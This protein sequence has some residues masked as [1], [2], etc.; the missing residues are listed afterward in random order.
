MNPTPQYWLITGISSGL[1]QA[2]ASAAMA[3][4]HYVIGTFRNPD[5]AAAFSQAH[6]GSGTAFPLDITDR[7]GAFALIREV[8]SRFGRLDVLVNNAG[9]GFAGAI[10]EASEAEVRALMEVSF[11]GPLHLTQAAL[12]LMRQQGSGHII[13]ISSHGGIKAFP[14]FGVYHAGKFAL[15][16]FS[17][18]LAAEAAPLGIRVTLVEP[19]PFRTGFAGA[20]F[21]EAAVRIDAYEATAGAFR[22]RMRQVHGRQEGDPHKAAQAILQI[23]AMEQPPLRLPLGKIA[24]GTIAA[25]LDSVR[26]DL[27]TWRS[28]AEGAVFGP[29]EG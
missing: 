17:E 2:L 23:A 28:V 29:E 22:A 6:A 10:E 26:Q 27:E 8:E 25:K 11:F 16:G 4:G 1:G 14:G 21:R 13:Q 7:A 15:E 20:G 24:L 5:Q 3:A 18:A 19:G 12:P 9:A